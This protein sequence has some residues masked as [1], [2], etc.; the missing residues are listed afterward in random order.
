MEITNRPLEALEPYA[1]NS[2]THSPEQIAQLVASINEFGW[3]NPVLIDEHGGVIAGHGRIMAARQLGMVEVPCIVLAGLTE[4]QKRAY[5]IA[6]NKLAL[7]AGWDDA[8]LKLELEE[9]GGLD[10]NLELT[11]FTL[12]ELN[13]ILIEKKVEGGGTRELNPDEF[14]L[15]QKCPR[16]G[17]EYNTKA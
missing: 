16:C 14:E 4:T 11:G 10:F 1:R 13:D 17:F 7:G 3:T 2:R 9:L 15:Q 6:D 12:P 5:V 8:M